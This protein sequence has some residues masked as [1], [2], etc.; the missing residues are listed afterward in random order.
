MGDDGKGCRPAKCRIGEKGG[1]NQEA[2]GKV[3][4]AVAD[5]DQHR[6]A[7]G[8]MRLMVG[9]M[10]AVGMVGAVLV[11]VVGINFGVDFADP[12]V[13]MA[14]ESKFFQRKETKDAAK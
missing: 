11:V 3:V 6:L 5:Q 14:P 13:G 1:S 7:V 9:V 12:V 10:M 2:V 8:I 4:E